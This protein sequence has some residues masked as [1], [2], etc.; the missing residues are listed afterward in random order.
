MTTTK[1]ETPLLFE[2]VEDLARDNSDKLLEHLG[3][4][5]DNAGGVRCACPIHGGDNPS[6]FSYDPQTFSWKCWTN[7]CHENY[8]CS[9]V[10]LVKA[11]KQYSN[12]QAYQYIIEICGNNIETKEIVE[13]R[14]YIKSQMRKTSQGNFPLD[15]KFIEQFD[16]AEQG[17]PDRN[18]F[19]T[20]ALKYNVRISNKSNHVLKNRIIF[21]IYNEK[22]ELIGVSGRTTSDDKTKW[23][24]YPSTLRIGDILWPFV[25][26]IDSLQKTKTAIL[27]EGPF[28]AVICHQYGFTNVLCVFGTNITMAQIKLLMKYGVQKIK[29]FFDP[30]QAGYKAVESGMKKLQLYFNVEVL[31]GYDKDPGEMT[32]EELDKLLMEKCHD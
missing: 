25:Q 9:L 32:R 10:G 4:N 1:M 6:G 16:L 2:Q 23:Y 22:N 12:E 11:L 14:R 19:P 5:L 15:N 18:I 20:T 26:S 29:L 17:I 7:K 24:H 30:D 13:L 21:P 3:F 28:D 8:G 27:V 31:S